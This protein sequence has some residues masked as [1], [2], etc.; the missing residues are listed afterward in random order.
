MDMNIKLSINLNG[1]NI[2]NSINR[3]HFSVCLMMFVASQELVPAFQQ[4]LRC[5]DK[6]FLVLA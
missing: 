1:K 5:L 2:H 6:L 3:E 4:I